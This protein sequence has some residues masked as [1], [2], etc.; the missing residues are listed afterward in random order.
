MARQSI[1]VKIAADPKKS[2]L[3]MIFDMILFYISLGKG[4]E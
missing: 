4:I 3:R 2:E 1:N